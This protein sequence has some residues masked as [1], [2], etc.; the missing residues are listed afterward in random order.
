MEQCQVSKLAK[1]SKTD[2]PLY[3]LLDTFSDYC[4]AMGTHQDRCAIT[5]CR[6]QGITALYRAN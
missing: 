6:G 3:N 4:V 1:T 2:C 5:Q